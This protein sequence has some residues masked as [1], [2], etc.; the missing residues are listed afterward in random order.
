MN[1]KRYYGWELIKL[2]SEGKIELRRKIQLLDCVDCWNNSVP[3]KIYEYVGDGCGI[4]SCTGIGTMES[5]KLC[6]N[7]K[8]FRIMPL[9]IE[10][11]DAINNDEIKIMIEFWDKKHTSKFQSFNETME[12]LKSEYNKYEISSILKKGKIYKLDDLV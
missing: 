4:E 8:R 7:R 5:Y 2:I 11:S 9:E 3:N 1:F 10:L 6:D 12:E